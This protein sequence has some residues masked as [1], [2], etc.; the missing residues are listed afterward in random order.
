MSDR[1]LIAKKLRFIEE[2]LKDLRRLRPETIPTDPMVAAFAERRLQVAIQAAMD[3]ASRVVSDEVLG[4]PR[5]NR[6]M[7]ELLG[8]HHWLPSD[9]VER[10]VQMVGFRNILVHG[11]QIVDP[12]RVQAIV[13]DN[14]GDLDQFIRSIRDRIRG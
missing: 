10:L 4:E 1:D 13:T 12:V 8:K 6:D 2:Q 5:R 14:L 9:L 11:Y 3:V 7:F